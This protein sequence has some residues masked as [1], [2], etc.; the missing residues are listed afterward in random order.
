MASGAVA[1]TYDSRPSSRALQLNKVGPV[2][3]TAY[4][5]DVRYLRILSI[6]TGADLEHDRHDATGRVAPPATQGL[7]RR[8]GRR[9]NL[10][11]LACAFSLSG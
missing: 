3:G 5:V 8:L 1:S 4:S 6:D 9:M 2:A 11:A 7:E 10:P